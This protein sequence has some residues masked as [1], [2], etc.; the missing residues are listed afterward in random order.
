MA[1][2]EDHPLPND[3]PQLL[4]SFK[5]RV[6]QQNRPEVAV[7]GLINNRYSERVEGQVTAPFRSFSRGLYN[8]WLNDRLDRGR[9]CHKEQ[10]TP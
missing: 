10:Y 8:Q 5:Y 1:Y 2:Q 4:P 7:A 3:W 6:F 9:H